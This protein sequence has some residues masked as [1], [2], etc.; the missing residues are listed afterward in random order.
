MDCHSD[1]PADQVAEA[2][3]SAVMT[4]MA[5]P[6]GDVP[7]AHPPSQGLLGSGPRFAPARACALILS[8]R[9]FSSVY[10]DDGA[11]CKSGLLCNRSGAAHRADRPGPRAQNQRIFSQNARGWIAIAH[12]LVFEAKRVKLE[13]SSPRS[14]AARNLQSRCVFSRAATRSMNNCV[15]AGS[16]RVAGHT[17]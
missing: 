2:R 11:H 17:A 3:G 10:E 14:I 13:R 12:V 8:C 16:T 5:S 15:L 7:V 4:S 9:P 6:A 1:R